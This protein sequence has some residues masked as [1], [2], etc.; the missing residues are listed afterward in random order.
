MTKLV[1]KKQM[2]NQ[3]KRLCGLG[4]VGM[5][6]ISPQ[7]YAATPASE[8]NQKN[9]NFF[10][11]LYS[12]QQGLGQAQTLTTFTQLRAGIRN[13]SQFEFYAAA[14]FGADSRTLFEK[15]TSVY[16]DNYLFMGVGVDYPGLLPGV[17]AI[18]QL[19]GSK[20]LSNKLDS[21]GLDGRAGVVTY[22]EFRPRNTLGFFSE[23]YSE[24][25]YVHRYKNL[26]M[27]GQLR[28]FYGGLSTSKLFGESFAQKF[29][30]EPML[31][32]V[33]S[34]DSA[35]LDFNRFVEAR[36][37]VRV[38]YHGPIEV[39]LLPHYVVGGRYQQPTQYPAYQDLRLLLV[40]A[41]D[42]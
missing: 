36:M 15:G 18:L 5:S 25:L 35:G 10:S 12:E 27:S 32:G 38:R 37:G 13:S 39:Q 1:N 33:V 21:G 34:F 42:F 3:M 8:V 6:L 9:S 30:I 40:L 26:M 7:V 17:R 23:V 2:K 28:L 14:R 31:Y 22:H 20:D 19:G 24:A 4:A 16:N 41:K 11:D 29:K